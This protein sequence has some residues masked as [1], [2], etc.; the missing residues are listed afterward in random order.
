MKHIVSDGKI[1]EVVK[2]S[3]EDA[4]GWCNA[5]VRGV[6][7]EVIHSSLVAANL[8]GKELLLAVKYKLYPD[9]TKKIKEIS[10]PFANIKT[11]DTIT[12]NEKLKKVKP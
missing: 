1:Y 12:I 2:H 11:G 3:K 5:K 4:S 6:K 9:P 7:K 8:T 10:P